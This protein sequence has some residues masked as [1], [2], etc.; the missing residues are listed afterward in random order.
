LAFDDFDAFEAFFL[1]VFCAAMRMLST[2][3]G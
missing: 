3:F 2:R 1:E